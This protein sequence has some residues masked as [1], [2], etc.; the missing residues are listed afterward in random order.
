MSIVNHRRWVDELGRIVP[1]RVRLFMFPDQPW[2][3]IDVWR[4]RFTNLWNKE[5]CGLQFGVTGG[6]GRSRRETIEVEG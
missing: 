2:P 1:T 5:F 6:K 4:N 3:D